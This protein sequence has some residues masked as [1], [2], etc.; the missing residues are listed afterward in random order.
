MMDYEKLAQVLLDHSVKARPGDW[1]TISG[2]S[3]AEPLVRALYRQTLR[4]GAHP[5]VILTFP[6][7]E[8]IFYAEASEEQLDYVPPLRWTAVEKADCHISILSEA[9]TRAL[10]SADPGRQARRKA[11]ERQLME[12]YLERS[13][14]GEYRWCVTLYPTPAFA[15]D[16]DMGQLEFENFVHR[17]CLLDQD[18]PVAAWQAVSRRQ[19]ALVERLTGADEIHL[20]GRGTDLR[21]SVKDRTWLNADGTHN[22]PDGEVFT[23]PVEASVEGRIRFTYPAAHFGREVE[24]VE[25]VFDGGRVV[26]ARAGKNEAFLQSMLDTDEGARHVGEFSFGAN[27]G[28]QRFIK[29]TLFDEKIGGTVHLALG[30]SY[31]ETG[32]VNQSAVHWDMVCDLREGGKVYVD[33]ELFAEDGRFVA[34]EPAR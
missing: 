8:E 23:G 20:L 27:P 19:A 6:E 2:T 18:D 5:S 17:A 10:S 32:G 24:G 21:L 12:R 29:N 30:S 28:I 22:F 26:E 31:P 14:S 16:A 13:A 11:A 4:V 3:L 1:V 7:W 25:L 34:H 9:N 33:G 15:Q